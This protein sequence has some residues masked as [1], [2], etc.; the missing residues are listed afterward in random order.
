MARKIL[1]VR[2]PLLLCLC[3]AKRLKH[4]DFHLPVHKLSQASPT[5]NQ[6]QQKKETRDESG[7][8]TWE[9]SQIPYQMK[10]ASTRFAPVTFRKVTETIKKRWTV[11][12]SVWHTIAARLNKQLRQTIRSALGAAMRACR[13][14]E[15]R[16]K[17]QSGELLAAGWDFFV[18]IYGFFYG[19]KARTASTSF[20]A[21]PTLDPAFPLFCFL[22]INFIIVKINLRDPPSSQE[23][24]NLCYL[25]LRFLFFFFSFVFH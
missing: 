2:S 6:C 21:S 13:V 22:L 7:K 9:M 10:K 24:P 3:F 16:G 15:R 23:S 18:L 5:A 4:F 8:S 25:A 14:G 1:S 19:C 17:Q 12:K 20:L 11:P